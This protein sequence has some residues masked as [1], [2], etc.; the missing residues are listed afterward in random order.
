MAQSFSGTNQ[1]QQES[2]SSVV[3]ETGFREAVASWM[4]GTCG[5]KL[6]AI[7]QDCVFCIDLT[8]LEE[9]LFPE[10]LVIVEPVVHLG[11]RDW[12]EYYWE[13]KWVYLRMWVYTYMVVLIRWLVFGIASIFVGLGGLLG[14]GGEVLLMGPIVVLA[15]SI[16]L[17]SI[18]Y[19]YGLALL[20]EDNPS[21]EDHV[22]G[23]VSYIGQVAFPLYCIITV[24]SWRKITPLL[25]S[26]WWSMVVGTWWSYW[27]AWWLLM[28]LSV[29]LLYY[30]VVVGCMRLGFAMYVRDGRALTSYIWFWI[31]VAVMLVHISWVVGIKANLEEFYFWWYFV[32]N[33]HILTYSGNRCKRLR[34]RA[35]S[36]VRIIALFS[37]HSSLNGNNGSWTNTDDVDHAA[38]VRQRKEA[39]NHL[40]QKGFTKSKTGC[41]PKQCKFGCDCRI[42][43]CKF[44]HPAGGGEDCPPED[45]DGGGDDENKPDLGPIDEQVIYLVLP[46]LAWWRLAWWV[47]V[48]FSTSFSQAVFGAHWPAPA[49]AWNQY[50]IRQTLH[51]RQVFTAWLGLMGVVI[52]QRYILSLTPITTD[53]HLHNRNYARENGYTH[54][55]SM[56]VSEK[57]VHHLRLTHRGST[58][59]PKFIFA[60]MYS[61]RQF[62]G[63]YSENEII[64]SCCWYKN[65]VERFEVLASGFNSP[66]G[67]RFA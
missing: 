17:P 52:D 67:Y 26:S 30:V 56:P 54:T 59:S 12:L 7:G 25:W 43:G 14:M 46:R 18:I 31:D 55:C 24:W 48:A 38:R 47:F 11:W 66:T 22:M 44:Q 1:I 50:I 34:D 6:E 63:V 10:E 37:R 40:H 39:K 49:R 21:D 3:I 62:G 9:V 27:S 64:G 32:F 42:A 29:K 41:G 57:I 20:W 65:E 53:V 60:L 28:R 23:R 45:G 15:L 16:R 58:N 61:C 5:E 4:C 2:G 13:F 36:V 8:G 35:R 51:Y 33:E 19:K